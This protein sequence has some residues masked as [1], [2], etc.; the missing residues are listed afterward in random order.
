MSPRSDAYTLIVRQGPE[1]AKAFAGPRDKGEFP[2]ESASGTRKFADKRSALLQIAN[3]SIHLL[4]S[5]Y[6]SG[7]LRIQPSKL[8][9]RI[10]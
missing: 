5:N 7:I 1:R 3:L 6:E 9:D 2:C 10:L 8:Q 4:S